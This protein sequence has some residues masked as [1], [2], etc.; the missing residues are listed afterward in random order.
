MRIVYPVL[1]S[2]PERK[3]CHAQ[4]LATVAALARLGHEITLLVPRRP[5][6][7]PL[8]AALLRDFHGVKGDFAVR[9]SP[10]RWV[11]DKAVPSSLLLLRL[12][13]DPLIEASEMLLCRAPNL[14]AHGFGCPVPVAVDHYRPWPDTLPILRPLILRQS[15]QRRCLGFALHSDFAADSF[16][17]LGCPPEKLLVAHNGVDPGLF[18]TPLRIAEAR[19]L[20]GLPEGRSIA[21]YAGRVN[22]QKGLDQLLAMARAAP[23]ILFVLVGSEGKGPIEREAASLANVRIFP[24]QRPDSLPPFL[25]AADILLIPPSS[26]PLVEHGNCVLPLKIFSYLAAARPI[27]APLS[28]DTAGL[29]VHEETA[30]LSP[31]DD[32]EAAVA[33]VRRLLADPA[34]GDRLARGA[35]K[36]AAGLSW[37][38]RARRL[39]GFFEERLASLARGDRLELGGERPVDAGFAPGRRD[40]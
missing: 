23:D 40:E 32:V 30:L 16:R 25:F 12:L 22:A 27:V 15:R 33:A 1:W 7:P 13:R 26:A 9:Q 11:G 4:T 38:G 5:H 28:P 2:R 31:P 21:L 34:L 10:G 17:R 3:A 24:W 35:R 8:D 29:L 19:R 6:D 14:M 36:K 20:T 39:T 18:E 37:D